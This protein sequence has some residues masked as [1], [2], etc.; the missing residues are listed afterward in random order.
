MYMRLIFFL[1]LSNLATFGCK[2]SPSNPQNTLRMECYVRVLESEEQITAQAT[3]RDQA[4]T[5]KTPKE[6]KG[7]IRYQG[8]PMDIVPGAGLSYIKDFAGTYRP[9]HAFSWD[10]EDGTKRHTLS[11]E[12]HDMKGFGFGSSTLQRNKPATFRWESAPLERGEALVFMWEKSDRSAAQ[13]MEIYNSN[14]KPEIEFPASKLSELA[15]G[16]WTLY[17]VRKRLIKADANG[18]PAQAVLEFYSQTDT[19]VI[20]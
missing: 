1:I 11:L 13:P 12:M 16:T 10:T 8:S 7:G 17:I 19:L 9:D 20:K 18:I 3:L 4:T 2:N 14:S 15:P 6:I 5:N